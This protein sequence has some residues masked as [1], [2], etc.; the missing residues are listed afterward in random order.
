MLGKKDNKHYKKRKIHI[1]KF[2]VHSNIHL[3]YAYTLM[4][5]GAHHEDHLQEDLVYKSKLAQ[6]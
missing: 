4:C 2:F 3:K 5:I 1:N 6:V